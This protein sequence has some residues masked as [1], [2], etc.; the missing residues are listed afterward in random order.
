MNPPDV[1]EQRGGILGARAPDLSAE[2]LR[3]IVPVLPAL[4]VLGLWLF[5]A[6]NS[7][8]YFPRDWYPSA[9][10][11]VALAL[12]VGLAAGR[13]FP[14]ARGARVALALLA[15][16]VGWAYLSL[17]WADSTGSALEA[18]N[19]M[20]L[21]LALAWTLALLPWDARTARWL[22]GL[23]A[24]GLAIL[25]C[26][27][28]AGA[29]G[30]N[31]LSKYLFEMRYQHPVGYANGN[32]ALGVIG[33][34]AAFGMSTD[35][36]A[37]PLVSG[38]FLAAA[39]LLA[40]FALLAQSRASFIGTVAAAVVFLIFAPDRLRV[41][42]RLLA[43]A[44]AVA[45]AAGPILNVYDTGEH[46]GAL[47]PALDDGIAAIP[48]SVLVAGAAGLAIGALE[49]LG[50]GRERVER[51]SRR[52]GIAVA[53]LLA[54][55]AVALALVNMGRITDVVD[56]QW[57]TL[58]GGEYESVEGARISNLD[59]YER[60]DYW[61]VAIDL[62]Q[63]SPV[64]GVGAGNFE[65]EYTARR[66][67]PKHSR[68]VH[69]MF[70]RALGEGGAVAAALL[71]GFFLSLFVFGA[72]LRRRLARAPALVLATTLAIAAYFAVHLNFDWLEEIP[73]VASPALAL[74]IVA[75]VAAGGT[76]AA[77]SGGTSGA[78]RAGGL[79]VAAV[80]VAALLALV[81]AYLSVRYLNRAEERAATDVDGAFEDLDRA[82][83][84]NGASLDP[85]LA[86][87]RIAIAAR[88]YDRAEEAFEES[89]TVE[90]NWLAYYEL[91][92]IDASRGRFA[93]AREELALAEAL[94]S[95]DPVLRRLERTIAARRRV[96]PKA[97]NSRIQQEAHARFTTS[98][99]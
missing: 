64:N 2:R 46:G 95:H 7:G 77:R 8:G 73:A 89:L 14:A 38:L 28:L 32:A 96:D 66:H 55:G 84:L 27:S 4:P 22:I 57:A 33:L 18:S 58:T 35:R 80:G 9:L 53:V 15:A 29:S 82:H 90:E 62:W 79:A 54:V 74:P 97:E 60:P 63:E 56:E 11:A 16:Y 3:S 83:S 71:V 17:L 91:A 23:W 34:I 92:L 65:R 13:A 85:V 44:G 6:P 76:A 26:F 67:E 31:D 98:G 39:A 42:A 41:G 19:K 87:G 88:R 12:M 81:P 47:G 30:T 20:L 93:R 68:Y 43:L 94:N 86:E 52:V 61:R 69:N 25:A 49:R 40:E 72:I 99:T 5:L 75:L 59:P 50:R 10:L 21:L 1:A 36:D 45:L 51:S 37:H 70:L 48:L 24:L 78:R